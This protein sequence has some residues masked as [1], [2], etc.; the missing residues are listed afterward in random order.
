MTQFVTHKNVSVVTAILP[1][2]IANHVIEEVFNF[3]ERNALLINARGTLMRD[4][5]YQALLPMMSPEK[6]YLQFLVPDAEVDR[7]MES[8]VAAGQL[9][10]PGTGAVIA[11]PCDELRCTEDFALWSTTSW[12]ADSL[13]ASHNLK[14]NLTAI[15]CIVQRNRTDEISRAAMSAG[16][17]GPV[18]FYCAGRGLR[19]RMGWL[20]I[21]KKD[22]QE[23][24][25]VIVDNADAVA[26]TEA[27]VDAGDIDMPGR[28]F[29]YR[30]PVQKGVMNVGSTYGRRKH[31]A[32]MQQVITAIDDLKGGSQWRDHRITELVGTG[33][34][35]GLNLFGKVKERAYLIDQA[36]LS[37]IVGRKHVDSIVDAALA[38]GAPGANVNYARLIEVDSRATARGIR[39]NRERA[40][41][42]IILPEDRLTNVVLHMQAACQELAIDEVCLY[43]QP[44]TR[45][46]TYIA[47]LA[48][49]TDVV[50]GGGPHRV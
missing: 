29:L 6:E 47:E 33:K 35:A 17:H 44:V 11:V 20:S 8:I 24:L 2:H 5:W 39:F 4:R 42:R 22:D 30:M 43:G 37:C 27:M 16:A 15:F 32:D 14:E 50:A 34:S 23:V 49:R 36:S 45:A 40:I 48:G 46:V 21:T 13:N 25:L 1:P 41:V 31:A 7:M 18:V 9:H 26:V 28:G 19:D 3:G 12:E 10:L 38:G